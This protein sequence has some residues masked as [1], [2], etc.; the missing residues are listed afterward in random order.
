MLIDSHAHVNFAA[1]KDD[2]DEVI[3]RALDN[4]VFLINVGSQYSTSK[5]AVEYAHKY[6]TGVWAAI[7]VHPIQLRKKRLNYQDDD[8]LLPQEIETIGENFDCEKYLELA[9]DPKV[10]AIGEVGLDY[11]HFE[12]GDDTEEMKA[13]QKKVFS[14]S[15][16]LANE[17]KKPLIVHCWDAYSDLYDILSKKPAEKKGV[18]HSFV[19]GYKTA[20]K[21]I[22]LGYKIGLNGVITYSKSFDRLIREISLDDI[23]LE[24]DCPYLAPVPHKGKR[25][26]PLNV[27]YVAEKIA[28][29]KEIP[30]KEVEEI[31][32]QNTQKL[33]GI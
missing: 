10:V 30:L 3:K 16:D 11:H 19:G 15:I 25:N 17:V 20:R 32:V 12:E 13:E 4:K 23:I 33:F 5:R 27:R 26:E 9:K 29:I 1:F 28:E 14:S 2:A 22:E 24:T 7:G 18:I 31:T 21:F 6:E 8:E